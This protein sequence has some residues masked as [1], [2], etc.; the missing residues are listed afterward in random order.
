VA[1]A[2][3]PACQ[4]A[5]R[6]RQP[7]AELWGH[8]WLV[9]AAFQA[10]DLAAVDYELGCI[11]QFAAYRRHGLAW[12]HLHRLRATRAALVGDLGAAVAHN[13]A[14]RAV[15]ARIGAFSTMGI[16]YAFLHQF[17]LLRGTIDRQTGQSA[18]AMLQQGH[19]IPL[20]RVFIPQIYALLGDYDLAR[21]A[22][23]EFRQMP[24][25]IEV[26]PRWA[27]LLAHIGITALM[28]D[29]TDT[30]GRVYQELSGLT[31]GYTDDGTG[32]VFPGGSEQRIAGDLALATG[33]IDEAIH[34]YTDAIEMN[35][36]IGARPFL[37]LSRL[38][39][40]KALA[41]KGNPA[42]L[43]AERALTTDATAEFP[44]A[45]PARPAG[46]RRR[47]AHPHRLRSQP[48]IT[49]GIRGGLADRARD[50]QPAD[51]RAAHL[52]RT[53][54]GNPRPQHPGQ[55]RLLHTH[56]NRHLVTEPRHPIASPPTTASLCHC[57]AAR[58]AT[59]IANR[60][61]KTL[62]APDRVDLHQWRRVARRAGP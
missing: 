30:A 2:R 38:G 54:R 9:D 32:L 23:E 28:L 15:A 8:V 45:R 20:V 21:A 1:R 40:A 10:G 24:G 14:A 39:L 16:Y 59:P 37:A 17:A 6:A 34:R 35:A 61:P 51:R 52:V 18:L 31:P 25:T 53:H 49:Q 43:P 4:V 27:A 29:D 7:L 55:A 44:A 11:E 19:G 33:R 60:Q 3:D 13:E 50:V 42:D 12:W 5:H 47:P 36:R 46:R 22:F 56:R 58:Q 57:P 41:A 62:M 48:A 26:G